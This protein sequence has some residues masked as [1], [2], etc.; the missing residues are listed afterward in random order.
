M[1][2][3]LFSISKEIHL[4]TIDFKGYVCLR[5]GKYVSIYIGESARNALRPLGVLQLKHDPDICSVWCPNCK[6]SFC[7]VRVRVFGVGAEK[8]KYKKEPTKAHR[9][10]S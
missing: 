6:P 1:F 2:Q 3:L 5:E 10:G 9:K 4:P 7:A 8:E